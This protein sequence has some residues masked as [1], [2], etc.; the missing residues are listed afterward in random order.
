M[1]TKDDYVRSVRRPYPVLLAWIVLEGY[2]KKEYFEPFLPGKNFFLKEDLLANAEWYYSKEEISR[3]TELIFN[4]WM[5]P[6]LFEEAK[7]LLFERE[8]ALL[9]AA[10]QDF[11]EFAEAFEAYMPAL[12][13]IWF[14]DSPVAK[15]ARELLIAK[16]PKEEAEELVSELNIPEQDNYYKK[17][18]Y[19]LVTTK[20]L[21]KHVDEYEWINSRYGE[22]HPYTLEEAQAKLAKIDRAA[23]LKKWSEDKENIHKTIERAKKILG[24]ED[25]H[26]IDFMQFIVFYR[27][28]RTDTMYKAMYL[29]IPNFKR[30]AKKKGITYEQLL[31]CTKQEILGS[32]PSKE[33]LDA[34]SKGF[35]LLLE[36]GDLRVVTGKDAEKVSAIL[37][38]DVNEVNEF[39]GAV[40]C[41][42]KIQGNAKIIINSQDYAKINIGDILVTSMT[43]PDMVPIMK[44]AAAFVTNEGGITCHAAIISREM[45]KPCIIGTRI[46]TQVLKDDDMIEVD[47]TTGIVKKL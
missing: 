43:T 7:K 44:K 17:E 27:T 24:K 37:K 14:C 1:L 33:D 5:Q 26:I 19:D 6:K 47:A 42:G 2:R 3:G 36:N 39:K 46:A 34:R 28:Q 38:D 40:A 12:S 11:E 29:Q 41:K 31:N 32:L 15:K 8:N 9:A 30:L 23:F 10:S 22:E 20:N 25:S 4:R 13:L 21:K 45:K 35:A 18:E 16:L